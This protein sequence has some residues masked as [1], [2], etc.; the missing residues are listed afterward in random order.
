MVDVLLEV[1]CLKSLQSDG[2]LSPSDK[3]G[4]R[5]VAKRDLCHLGTTGSLTG[6]SV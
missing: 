5:P 3:G 1:V 2:S 4:I 6:K